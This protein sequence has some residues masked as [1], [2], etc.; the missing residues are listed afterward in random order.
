MD[1]VVDIRRNSKTYGKHLKFELS[2]DNLKQLWIPPGFA[3]GFISLEDNTL[4]S[5]KCT[6][7]YSKDH[8]MDLLWNDLNLNIEWNIKNPIISEKDKNA[9]EFANFIS[10]F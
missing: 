5:Y 6:N 10:P 8:E 7:H 1:V 9:K 3:H 4:L 2:G